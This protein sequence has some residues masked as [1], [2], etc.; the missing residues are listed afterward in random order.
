[1]TITP[2]IGALYKLNCEWYM[3][4]SIDMS[5]EQDE[6]TRL[7]S[8]DI[9]MLVDVKDDEGEACQHYCFL[10]NERMYWTPMSEST[11]NNIFRP[12]IKRQFPWG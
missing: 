8:S 9:C 6:I 2:K 7:K 11:F 12:L 4:K 10:I 5:W 1:M 3:H